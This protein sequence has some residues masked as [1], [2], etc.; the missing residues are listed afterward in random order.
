MPQVQRAQ[1][2]SSCITIFK[3][4]YE[5]I[6]IC[7]HIY[8]YENLMKIYE[9]TDDKDMSYQTIIFMFNPF[10]RKGV[11]IPFRFFFFLIG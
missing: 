1:K 4:R 3:N 8:I 9:I 11:H 5:I 10:W 6:D 7:I 2:R